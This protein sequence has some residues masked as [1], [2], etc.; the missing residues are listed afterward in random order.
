VSDI[1]RYLI[2]LSQP[3]FGDAD[4]DASAHV[5]CTRLFAALTDSGVVSA[6]AASSSS[7]SSGAEAGLVLLA[8]A[9]HLSTEIEASK[10]NAL[11]NAVGV[12][13]GSASLLPAAAGA[14][15][16]SGASDAATHS[17]QALH[18]VAAGHSSMRVQQAI[19]DLER[20]QALR[21][22]R[23]DASLERTGAARVCASVML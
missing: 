23:V 5:L 12:L 3:S 9:V 6:A 17:S 10:A 16:G 11:L 14:S 13:G 22:A 8:Q 2:L 1:W 4:D 21:R 18:A 19:L 20:E 15:N 7:S